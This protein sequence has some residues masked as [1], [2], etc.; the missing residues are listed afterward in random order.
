MIAKTLK[1]G[2]SHP[3]RDSLNCVKEVMRNQ[4]QVFNNQNNHEKGKHSETA[5]LGQRSETPHMQPRS[6]VQTATQCVQGV[7]ARGRL[8]SV[9]AL[10]LLGPDLNEIHIYTVS[11]SH[12]RGQPLVWSNSTP[13]GCSHNN[14]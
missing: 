2:K 3:S 4:Q 7:T 10:S 8:I 9:M 14:S 6:T 11:G 13:R 1:C 12:D 5:A